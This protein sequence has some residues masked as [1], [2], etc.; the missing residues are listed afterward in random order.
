MIHTFS[1]SEEKGEREVQHAHTGSFETTNYSIVWSKQRKTFSEWDLSIF[2]IT[3]LR[4]AI[5]V[6]ITAFD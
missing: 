1:F 2:S 5:K 4:R 3:D 6:E